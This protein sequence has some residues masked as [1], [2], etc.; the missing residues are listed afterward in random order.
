[1][2]IAFEEIVCPVPAEQKTTTKIRLGQGSDG[3]WRYGLQLA[4]EFFDKTLDVKP[5]EEGKGFDDRDA[6][7]VECCKDCIAR[8][9]SVN[10]LRVVGT[11]AWLEQS[12]EGEAAPAA[13]TVVESAAPVVAPTV[14]YVSQTP[15]VEEPVRSMKGHRLIE[16]TL[17]M[18]ADDGFKRIEFVKL[19]LR[20][21]SPIVAE[22]HLGEQGDAWHWALW[23]EWVKLDQKGSLDLRH[24]LT[25]P[26]LDSNLPG[27]PFADTK[28]AAEIAAAEALKEVVSR[29]CMRTAIDVGRHIEALK[30]GEDSGA[31]RSYW[32]DV[33]AE[34]PGP[35]INAS[36]E[37]AATESSATLPEASPVAIG[38][39]VGT[40]DSKTAVV[41]FERET[42]AIIAE[43]SSVEAVSAEVAAYN[44]EIHEVE[45][46]LS[47]AH[48]LLE[49]LTEQR[50]EA[51][52]HLK[53][54]VGR[55]RDLRRAGPPRTVAKSAVEAKA[56]EP[57]N[58]TATLTLGTHGAVEVTT[59]AAAPKYTGN[60]RDIPFAELQK[61]GLKPG[62]VEVCAENPKMP[63]KTFGDWADWCSKHQ[64]TEIAKVGQAKAERIADA[65][66]KFWKDNPE[67]VR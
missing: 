14:T 13:E 17:S 12:L 40:G 5:T 62:L 3:K 36:G 29:V 51:K 63:I 10:D 47:A 38:V 44:A 30:A 21:T 32:P 54:V 8:W 56:T 25:L 2:S 23:A 58:G 27:S 48:C 46:E 22:I 64:V 33:P 9:R 59:T 65:Y 37:V 60:W 57:T 24:R 66:E 1:M 18:F 26:E 16:Q 34:A 4:A 31:E 39:D 50:K 49:D 11:I 67:L 15:P 53:D 55:L 43:G 6:A 20:A 28:L 42:G 35:V 19:K 52:Q 7:F 45:Q 41:V 61:Y